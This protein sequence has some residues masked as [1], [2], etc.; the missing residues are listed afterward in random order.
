ML[1][2][3]MSLIAGYSTVT[4][5]QSFFKLLLKDLNEQVV[6]SFKARKNNFA[7]YKNLKQYQTSWKVGKASF[8]LLFLPEE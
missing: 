8:F 7:R 1:L 2:H 5:I 4:H 6:C 3:A